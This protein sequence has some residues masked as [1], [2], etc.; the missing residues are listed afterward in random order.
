MNTGYVP[1][2]LGT[3]M[4]FDLDLLHT[5]QARAGYRSS[6]MYHSICTPARVNIFLIRAS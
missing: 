6:S 2:I 5:N 1:L 4:R 3:A